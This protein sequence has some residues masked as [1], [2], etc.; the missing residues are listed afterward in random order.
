MRERPVS[1]NYRPIVLHSRCDLAG[2]D[3]LPATSTTAGVEK[4]TVSFRKPIPTRRMMI[5]APRLSFD[6]VCRDI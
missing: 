2:P 6:K 3:Y 4:D 5:Y 1:D